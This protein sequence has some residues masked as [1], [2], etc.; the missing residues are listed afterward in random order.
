MSDDL[1]P[2]A[3]PPPPPSLV[4]R[5]VVDAATIVA[6]TEGPAADADESVYFSDIFNNRILR[7]APG[8]KL[9]V[10][11]ADSGRTNGNLFDAQGRLVSC[12]GAEFGVPEGRR[13]IVRTD[14]KT[15]QV[16]VLADRYEGKRFNSP[17]DLAIDGRGR[18]YFTDP[19]YDADRSDL[20]MEVEAVYRLDPDGTVARL[21]TPPEIEKP[22]G[23]LVSPDDRR[24]YLVDSNPASGGA[25]RIRAFDLGG[26]GR[27]SGGRVLFDFAPGRGGDG[28]A[29]DRQGNLYVCAGINRLRGRP[30]ETLKYPT[31]VYILS[32]EGR[33][34]GFIPVPE[35]LITNCTFGGPDLRT[36]YITAGKTLFTVRVQN[37]GF[38]R[39]PPAG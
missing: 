9:S 5:P 12:E 34:L 32:P 28:M 20:E 30:G 25:R 1:K 3:W 4:E 38:L 24:L 13:R 37:Q 27:V 6:F 19:R 33:L 7:L 17:N 36:L 23:I 26:D 16:E 11:R 8:G 15:G 21:L 29:I 31:G 10:L 39:W 18:L 35:D 22:N 14:L 2:N